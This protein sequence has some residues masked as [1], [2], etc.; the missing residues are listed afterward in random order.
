MNIQGFLKKENVDTI[1]DV[2]IDEDIYKFLSRDNQGKIFQVFV[3]NIK[4]FFETERTKPCT[5]IDMNKKY[6]LLILNFIKTNY[7]HQ[8]PNKIKIYQESPAKELITYEEIQNDK[9]S[10]FE[11]DFINYSLL[12]FNF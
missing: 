9:K 5:L 4:G 7:P 3:D 1:W 6:I 2:I 10:Q 11:K 12:N 8:L